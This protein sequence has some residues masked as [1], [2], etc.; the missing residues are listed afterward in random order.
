MTLH[1]RQTLDEI[2]S[3]IAYQRLRL[4]QV[5]TWLENAN[6]DARAKPLYEAMEAMK[7]AEAIL[8]SEPPKA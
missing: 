8:A 4:L 7:K 6:D 1:E 3:A 5:I 2:A